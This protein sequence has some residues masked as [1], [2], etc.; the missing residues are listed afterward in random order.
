[1]F[2]RFVSGKIDEDSHVA[3]GLFCAA[4]DLRSAPE[5]PH[6]EVDALNELQD[7]F[8]LYLESP[9][10]YLPQCKRYELGVCW[11]RSTAREHLAKAWELVSILE[12]NDVLIWTIR[13]PRTGYIYYEDAVQ[14]FALPYYDL[15]RWLC[16]R[17]S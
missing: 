1:M 5:L 10:D 4:G 7:W 3:A 6:Y 16:A 11:F 17:R 13:S 9:F 15:R 14:V 2:I 8:N 12:R